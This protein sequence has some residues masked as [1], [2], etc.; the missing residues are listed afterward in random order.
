MLL[1]LNHGGGMM[2]M[3][4]NN[5]SLLHGVGD[6]VEAGQAVGTASAPTGVNTGVYFELRQNNKPVDPRSWLSR[7]R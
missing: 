4:G 5:E 3:Y 7:Q 6:Q 1:I 2:S